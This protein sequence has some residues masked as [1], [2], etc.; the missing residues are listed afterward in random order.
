MPITGE[1]LIG[2][3]ALRG[4]D[5]PIRATE[6]ATG[7]PLDPAFGGGTAAD[8]ERACALAWSAFDTYRETGLERARALPR[9][10]RR[11]RSSTSATR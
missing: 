6:A 11:R 8:V 4:T 9:G 1:M 3:T 2:A 5:K 10:D 7:K